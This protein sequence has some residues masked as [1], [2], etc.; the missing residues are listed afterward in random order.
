MA[1]QRILV[2]EDD[3]D[4]LNFVCDALTHEGYDVTPTES[5][6]DAL[7]ITE[8]SRFDLMMTDYILPGIDGVE[9][10]RILRRQV[11]STAT[12]LMSAYNV[13]QAVRDAFKHGAFDYLQKPFNTKVLLETVGQALMHRKVFV[14]HGHDGGAKEAVARFLEKLELRPIVLHEQENA[15]QTII[16]KLE[17]NAD[18]DFAVVLLTPDDVGYPKNTPQDGQPRARQNVIFE[19]GYF[20]GRLGRKRV[21]ALYRKEVELPTDLNGI[22]YVQLDDSDTWRSVLARAIQEAGIEIELKQAL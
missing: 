14:V 21:C 12:I 4:V 6:E 8:G 13:P 15:G 9:L 2:V 20:V 1:A 17:Y 11:R 16:E 5:G 7:R 22:L 18:V 3:K 19:L 10:L